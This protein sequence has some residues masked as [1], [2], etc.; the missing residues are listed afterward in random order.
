MQWN[1]KHWN[2]LVRLNIH[3]VFF[4]NKIC[5]KEKKS[6]EFFLSGKYLKKKIL[7]RLLKTWVKNSLK[8]QYIFLNNSQKTIIRNG[9]KDFFFIFR[10]KL[11]RNLNFI[12]WLYGHTAGKA[13]GID[14]LPA[15]L[16]L[17][18]YCLILSIYLYTLVAFQK[19]W[20]LQG[21]YH[22][23]KMKKINLVTTDLFSFAVLLQ[24][25]LTG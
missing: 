5:L 10:Q 16:S 24:K 23:M 20:K 6:Y 15:K 9:V 17:R 2:I 21:W 7:L 14:S 25:F 22:S 12:I 4:L 1:R 19:I 13:T 8:D 11:R 18:V 3:L